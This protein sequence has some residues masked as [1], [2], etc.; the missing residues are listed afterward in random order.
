MASR[1]LIYLA[2]WDCEAA[3]EALALRHENRRWTSVYGIP[4]GGCVPAVMV[5]GLLGL[6]IVDAPDENTLI[7]DD[8]VDSGKTAEQFDPDQFDALFRKPA[9]PLAYAPQAIVHDGWLVFP[10]EADSS[11]PE[12]AIVR[13]IEH[14]GEDPTRE[15]LVDTPKRVVKAFRE[16][17]SGYAIDPLKDLAVTFD[18]DVDQMV[19]LSNIHFDSLCEHHMLPFSGVAT[20]GYIP[21]GRIVGLSKLARVVEAFS[22]RLQVQERLTDQIADAIVEALDPKGVGVVISGHHSCMSLR[23]IRKAGGMMT[24]SAL[25]GK[26]KSDG[27]VRAEFMSLHEI[28]N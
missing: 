10:W 13:I 25:R 18:E 14:I 24:T 12:D 20:V 7:V 8:L 21:N 9:S 17:T 23:G 19:V 2:W 27:T 3:A 1:E 6:P 4:R 5:A 15:G 28:G 16:M 22:R 26:M 11:G